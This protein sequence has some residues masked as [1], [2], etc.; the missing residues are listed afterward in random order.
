MNSL[1]YKF[2]PALADSVQQFVPLFA[3]TRAGSH[4]TLDTIIPPVKKDDRETLLTEKPMHILIIDDDEVNNYMLIRRIQ[5]LNKNV[6]LSTA[7][8]GVDA[9]IDLACFQKEKGRPFPDMI[10]VD[11]DMPSMDGFE[12]LEHYEKSF[13]PAHKEAKVIMLT[14]SSL[15]K[16]RKKAED[17]TSVSEFVSKPFPL[18]LIT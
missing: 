4:Q 6:S 13:Y 16:D 17:F 7:L 5:E 11:I 3:L 8:N 9:L 10:L 14:S 18:S 12:F 2:T 1:T 15:G